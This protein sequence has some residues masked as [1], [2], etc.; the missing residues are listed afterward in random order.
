MEVGV[1]GNLAHKLGALT[2]S[3]NH[4]HSDSP[5]VEVYRQVISRLANLG[6]QVPWTATY[7]R[8]SSSSLRHVGLG[9][10]EVRDLAVVLRCEHHIVWLHIPENDLVG[11]EIPQPCKNLRRIT[12]HQRDGK[13]WAALPLQLALQGTPSSKLHH[14]HPLRLRQLHLE[15]AVKPH[16][17]GMPHD[18]HHVAFPI[19]ILDN[20]LGLKLPL[21][22]QLH[23]I[24]TPLLDGPSGIQSLN[25]EHFSKG[26]LPQH[27][28]FLEYPLVH[29]LLHD[30]CWCRIPLRSVARSRAVI[31][32]LDNPRK[33]RS[34]QSPSARHLQNKLAEAR[35]ASGKDQGPGGGGVC[36]CVLLH[37]GGHLDQ[38]T[39]VTI[40]NMLQLHRILGIAIPRGGLQW[41]LR[42]NSARGATAALLRQ[43]KVRA[44]LYAVS[45]GEGLQHPVVGDHLRG[46][47][48]LVSRGEVHPHPQKNLHALLLPIIRRHVQGGAPVLG[49]LNVH[50][51]TGIA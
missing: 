12:L 11:V 42:P 4:K 40:H 48:M 23:S 2:P 18:L 28:H 8:C 3:E 35:A 51:C 45:C 10:A 32:L 5:T 33:H 29:R 6:R 17:A 49:G 16:E 20:P 1:N 34:L 39:Q 15:R 47:H 50:V 46:L 7:R 21:V 19:C 27:L 38:G 30:W 36:L 26:S 9:Q 41:R 22:Q 43:R 25:L 44:L 31:V 13:T 24:H 14:Q 37:W